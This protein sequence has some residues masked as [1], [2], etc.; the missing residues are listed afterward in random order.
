MR[1][2][3]GPVALLALMSL[4]AAACGRDTTGG[5]GGEAKPTYKI[6]FMGDLTGPNKS[7]CI[8]P[9]NTGQLLAEQGNK[10]GDLPV[11]IEYVPEDTQ[12]DRDKAVPIAQ[13][14][15]ADASVIAIL[16][17]CFSGESFSTGP[18][19]EAAG[20]PRVSPS[21][22]N[23]GLAQLGWKYWFRTIANDDEQSGITPDVFKKYVKSQKVFI[24]HDKTAYGEGLATLVRDK[25]VAA[26]VNVVGFEAVDPGKEDYS[27]LVTKVTGSE[28]DTFYWGAYEKE[29]GLIVKQL[30]EKGFKGTFVAADG[31]KGSDF[32]AVGAASADGAVITC[33][34]VD[35]TTTDDPVAKKFVSDYRAKFNSEPTIYTS[36]AND[37]ML[38]IFEALKKAGTPT[39]D[40]KAYRD[41]VRD[42]IAKTKLKGIT[43]VIE[44]Q[45]SGEMKVPPGIFL[46]KVEGG[47][48]KLLGLAAELVK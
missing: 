48:Y 41:K 16:G 44:F 32:L 11:K 17:P 30:R 42:A 39:S 40:I 28:A 7:L 38:V 1:K 12:G 2:R 37:A 9:K 6:V 13:K 3:L 22:T 33:P 46:Y 29:A 21:A 26:G 25:S 5:G 36:E 34:C 23:P 10:S 19:F 35:P 14:Y 15:V 27:A 20:I 45:A 24:G 4:L 18:H 31:T 43:R 47:K 8:G